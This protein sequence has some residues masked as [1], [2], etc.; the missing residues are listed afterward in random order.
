MVT[1]QYIVEHLLDTNMEHL[2]VHML[3]APSAMEWAPDKQE[4]W[5]CSDRNCSTINPFL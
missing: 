5:L 2:A 3:A 4:V 1:R